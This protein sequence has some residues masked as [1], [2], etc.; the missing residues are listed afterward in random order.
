MPAY[1]ISDVKMRGTDAFE[2]C[3]SR[4]AASITQYGGRYLVQAG[5]VER[6]EGDWTPRAIVVVEFPD[7][8][9]AFDPS[10]KWP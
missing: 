5:A 10:D 2:S 6:L 3:R 4:A 9:R 7:M 8:E 1:A